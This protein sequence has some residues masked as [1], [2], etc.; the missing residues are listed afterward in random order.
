VASI[1]HVFVGMAAARAFAFRDPPRQIGAWMIRM[2]A[3][4]LLP[5]LDV[6]AFA[7]DVPYEAPWGHRGAT[8]SPAFALLVAAATV[9]LAAALGKRGRWLAWLFGWSFA[10]VASHG[11]LDAL[12]DGG[13]GVELL[14]PLGTKR[15]FLPW[16]PIPVAPLGPRLF[17]AEGRRVM[18]EECVYFAPFLI[19]ALA[20]WGLFA[21]SR[22]TPPPAP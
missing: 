21:T 12:T 13:R 4:S 19:A 10:V 20:P 22:R 16:Q 17:G 6:F 3:L 15:Y 2:S 9:A 7:F 5:D 14:W 11:V 1:G 18:L 8:H